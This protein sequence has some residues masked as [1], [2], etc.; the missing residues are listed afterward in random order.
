MD[1]VYLLW[2]IHPVDEDEKLI[3]VYR[4][5]E[6]AD[7][8]ILEL[9]EKPGFRDTVEGFSVD[10]YQMNRTHWRDGFIEA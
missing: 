10:E 2:H 1:T 6:D 8:A 7:S 5:R 9:R 4:T 3:G